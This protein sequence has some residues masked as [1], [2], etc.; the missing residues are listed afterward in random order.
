MA[1]AIPGNRLDGVPLKQHSRPYIHREMARP[2]APSNA[3][4]SLPARPR[5]D[6]ER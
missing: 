5:L 2:A 6:G 1:T 4:A 3:E